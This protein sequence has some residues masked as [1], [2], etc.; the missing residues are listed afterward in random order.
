LASSVLICVALAVFLTSPSQVTAQ[1]KLPIVR[2]TPLVE[3]HSSFW[4][5]LHEVLLN[6]AWPRVRAGKPHR[7]VQSTPPLSA[8]RMSKHDEANWNAAVNFYAAHFGSRQQFFDDQLIDII[9][10]LA[11]QPPAAGQ[12]RTSEASGFTAG[13]GSGLATRGRDS[14]QVLLAGS[15]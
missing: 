7:R 11:E 12:W 14:S 8:A 15:K 4:V 9:P 6:E 10:N 1:E 13:N 5:N 3:F 2:T